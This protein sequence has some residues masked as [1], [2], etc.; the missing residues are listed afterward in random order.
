VSPVKSEPKLVARSKINQFFKK[1]LDYV[2]DR[3]PHLDD[4]IH[5]HRIDSKNAD[6]IKT[7]HQKL[8]ESK[9]FGLNMYN[10]RVETGMRSMDMIKDLLQILIE[11][12]LVLQVGVTERVYVTHEFCQP[13]LIFS[14][15]N[16]KGRS[17]NDV[18]DY[19]N[20]DDLSPTKRLRPL[21]MDAGNLVDKQ[22]KRV[23][24]VPKPWRYIDGLL[25]RQVLQKMLESV[26][27]YLKSNPDSTFQWI[28]AHYCPVLQPVQT[29]DLLD[30]LVDLDCVCARKMRC[31]SSCSLESDFNN[32]AD[33]CPNA[34]SELGNEL[35]LYEC[36]NNAICI[37]KQVF[38]A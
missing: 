19:D 21:S 20:V 8:F 31:E 22:Y 24:L 30:M 5:T 35:V 23:N 32:E 37:I 3:V 4:I 33:Y 6:Q 25:N 29:L 27:L 16:Q 28:S 34:D 2:P 7:I 13:W 26:I 9:E 10:L 12:H 1:L 14:Y 11:N 36:T 38:E 15:K 17:C 18:T